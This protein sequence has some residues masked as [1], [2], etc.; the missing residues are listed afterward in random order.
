MDTA[1][2]ARIR[3][4]PDFVELE[5]SRRSFGW[6]LTILML[7]IYYGFLAV[8]A[9]VPSIIPR[10]LVGNLTVGIALGLGVIVSAVV[11]TGIYVLRANSRYDM[12][13]GRVVSAA[14]APV[15]V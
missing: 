6:T 9:F 4:N 3:A 14:T 7:S 10:P 1:L 2:A 8:V 5:S 12:L 13:L 15:R 11:L